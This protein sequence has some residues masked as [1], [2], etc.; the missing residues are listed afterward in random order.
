MKNR[1]DST[2][3]PFRLCTEQSTWRQHIRLLIHSFKPDPFRL[4]TIG[5]L[6]LNPRLPGKAHVYDE[7]GAVHAGAKSGEEKI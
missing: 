2:P 7:C 5:K 3:R 1:R 6:A 4:T